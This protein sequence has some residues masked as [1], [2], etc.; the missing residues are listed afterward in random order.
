VT[1]V[2][3]VKIF[4]LSQDGRQRQLQENQP[5]VFGKQSLFLQLQSGKKIMHRD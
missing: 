5:Y 3:D 2:F 4:L 1:F